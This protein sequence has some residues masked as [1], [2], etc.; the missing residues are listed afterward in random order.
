MGSLRPGLM[1]A[2]PPWEP[3][4]LS[5]P[6]ARGEQVH[7]AL[8]PFPSDGQ[9]LEQVEESNRTVLACGQALGDIVSSVN[10][11]NEMN[12]QIATAAE[13]Q[14]KVAEEITRNVVNIAHISTESTEAATQLNQ[15][16]HELEQ[17][18]NDLKAKVGQFRC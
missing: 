4:S 16:C 14:S 11:I 1:A 15:S 9:G 8:C 3:R 7:L 6:W 10:V 17:L 18:S 12:T 2:L 5:W 13:E